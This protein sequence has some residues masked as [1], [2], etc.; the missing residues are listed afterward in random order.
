MEVFSREQTIQA[1]LALLT[2]Y[3]LH[4]FG[5]EKIHGHDIGPNSAARW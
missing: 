4:G 2:T 5:G 1:I 3:Y